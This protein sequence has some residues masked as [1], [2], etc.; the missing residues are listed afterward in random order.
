MW[1]ILEKAGFIWYRRVN[2][3]TWHDQKIDDLSQV[4]ECRSNK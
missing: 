3:A 1:G 2:K 4:Q